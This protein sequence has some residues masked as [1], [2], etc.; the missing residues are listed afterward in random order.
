METESRCP[1]C[2]GQANSTDL[3][4]GFGGTHVE[5]Q[6]CGVFDIDEFVLMTG[7]GDSFKDLRRYLICHTRQM[8]AKGICERFTTDNWEPIAEEHRRTSP[9]SRAQLI[10]DHIARE[11]QRSIGSI[12]TINLR[13]LPLFDVVSLDEMQLLV[14]YLDSQGLIKNRPV[15]GAFMVSIRFDGWV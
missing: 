12:V 8:T 9:A 13:D 5:C 1:L 3:L 6:E 7:W 15:S 14:G 11:S 10:F 4:P 2:N